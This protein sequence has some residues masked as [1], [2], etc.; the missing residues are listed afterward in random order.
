MGEPALHALL[1][2][3]DRHW[4]RW[5]AGV[6]RIPDLLG[7]AADVERVEEFLQAP[8][9][10]VPVERIRKLVAG[11]DLSLAAGGCGEAAPG[12][13][14]TYRNLIREIESL[15]ERAAAGDRVLIH[16]SGHGARLPTVVTGK[17]GPGASDECLVPCDAAAPR[18]EGGGFLRDVELHALL[19]RLA[20]RGL[21]VTLILDCCH[22]G[23]VTREAPGITGGLRN[24]VRGLGDLWVPLEARTPGPLGGWEELAGLWPGR[25]GAVPPERRVRHV[26]GTA[27]WFPQPDGCVLLAACRSTELARESLVGDG[28]WSGTLT[29][30]L[31]QAVSELGPEP[32]YRRVHERLLAGI[33]SL[34]ETQ[35]PVLEGDPERIFLGGEAH[36]AG[37]APA[38]SCAPSGLGQASSPGAPSGPAGGTGLDRREHL[39]RY[40]AVVELA[41]PGEGSPLAGALRAE[42][43]ALERIDDWLDPGARRPLSP[44]PVPTGTLL[45]LR[46][47][48]RSHLDL[49]VAV[50]DLQPDGGIARVHPRRGEGDYSTIEAGGELPVFLQACLPEG[51]DR[52]RDLLKILAATGPLDVTPLELPALEG[53]GEEW[54]RGPGEEDARG[55]GVEGACRAK[56]GERSAGAAPG[57]AWIGSEVGFDSSS[58]GTAG[59]PWTVRS[60]ALAIVS[61]EYRTLGDR[62]Y[63]A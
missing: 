26:A 56:E 51:L 39:A 16:F 50:L 24:R 5:A 42:L 19:L 27:G 30:F 60:L 46:I 3:V 7:S 10:S 17:K 63:P 37:E 62:W 55:A 49:N 48:N 61:Q 6:G 47:E 13:L 8:P 52:G 32:T 41:G 14:P 18:G 2:G 43:F 29:H 38:G 54:M 45:C 22:S 4:P 25:E 31:L 44:D 21:Q 28:R 57:G 9:L 12:E 35:T 1:V 23:G 53:W 33:R 36:G 40:R 11:S 20:A 59:G 15:G 34:F 58:A